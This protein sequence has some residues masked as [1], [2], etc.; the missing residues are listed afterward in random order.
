MY[1]YKA[2]VVSVYD[3]DTITVNIDLGFGVMLKNQ[4]VRLMGISAPEVRGESREAGILSRNY[5]CDMVI[6]R[7]VTIRT[8]KT[9]EK[10]GRWLADVT[11]NCD[12]C[13]DGSSH[14]NVNEKMV[15]MGYAEPYLLK[16]D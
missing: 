9:K 4:K 2:F 12:N 13:P 5:L 11:V 16:E 14:I 6:N 15:R 1:E 3:G 7:S 10:Y 8:H